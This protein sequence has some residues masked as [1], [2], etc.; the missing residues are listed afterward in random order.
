MALDNTIAD[1]PAL[2]PFEEDLGEFSVEDGSDLDP[3]DFTVLCPGYIRKQGK[4]VFKSYC[5]PMLSLLYNL[6]LFLR[7]E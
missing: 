3:D 7:G 2:E 5:L 1:W 4:K 6:F